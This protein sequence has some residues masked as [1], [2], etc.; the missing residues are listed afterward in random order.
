MIRN[1]SQ[2]HLRGQQLRRVSERGQVLPIVALFTIVLFGMAALAI[3]VSR[4]YADL[5]VY[6]AAA[7]AASLAGAQDLQVPNSRAVSSTEQV[8]ARTHALQS[9]EQRLGAPASG[10]SPNADIINCALPNTAFAI[11]IKTPSPSCATC[12][13]ERSV[14]VTVRHLNYGLTFA[15]VLGSNEWDLGTTSV[16]GLVYGGQ[17]ALVTLRPP[18]VLP[19]GTDQNRQNIDVNG[20]NT[21]LTLVQGDIGTNTSAFT[22]SG[23]FIEL[24]PGYRI[25]HLDDITPDPWNKDLAGNPRGRL[26]TS[27]IPDP[28]YP[29]ASFAG[30]PQY[31]TQAAGEVP[32]AGNPAFPTDYLTVLVGAICYQPGIYDHNFN[33]GTGGGPSV[34]YLLPGAYR[35]DGGLDVR[36][37]LLGGLISNQPGVVLVVPQDQTFT[38]NNAVR[39]WLNRGAETCS[40]DTCRASAAIDWSGNQVKTVDDLILSIEVPRDN[41]CFSGNTPHLCSDNQNDALRL[42]GNGQLAVAGIIYAAS[43]KTQI[44]GDNTVQTGIVGQLITWTVTYGGGAHLSLDY[45]GGTGNGI[46][47]ID[48]A[49]SAP[50]EPCN[51]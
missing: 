6:R 29:I 12:D 33:V 50:G 18:D 37:S 11:S 26:I 10:C 20:T 21:L 49:C 40:S 5:R 31:A 36:G 43:D 16:S 9:L 47:R 7:D 25:H 48:A 30:A 8:R 28:N 27:L 2:R 42:P 19:N 38:G 46:L 45:P 1:L 35:F 44:Q 3:D 39:I 17:Y 34:A 13:P 51:P 14:Q 22:N 41:G 15:R 4:A 23:G 32:C 24:A